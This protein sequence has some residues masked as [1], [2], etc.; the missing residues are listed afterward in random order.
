M[1][2]NPQVDIDTPSAPRKRVWFHAPQQSRLR[3]ALFQIH[4]WVGLIESL[5]VIVIGLSGSALVFRQELEQKIEP[6][7]HFVQPAS[8]SASWNAVVATICAGN[9]GFRVEALVYPRQADQSAYVILEPAREKVGRQQTRTYYFNPY[10][11]QVLGEENSLEGPLGWITNLHYYLFA[12]TS[13]LVVN[14][15]M[16]SGLFVLCLT[17]IVLWWPGIRRWTNALTIRLNSSWRRLNW[18]LHTVVGLWCSVVLAVIAFTGM[19]FAFPVPIGTVTVLATGGN[20]KQ[21]AALLAPPRLSKTNNARALSLDEV[22]QVVKSSFPADTSAAFLMFS[23]GPDGIYTAVGYRRDAAPYAQGITLSIDPH[24]GEILKRVG[25]TQYPLG[26][27]ITQYFYTLHFGSFGGNGA[28]GILVKILWVI[29]G[30]VAAALGVTGVLMYWN[31]YLS[32]KW[33]Q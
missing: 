31:R 22:L 16:A 14:G 17:G 23:D 5:Y 1:N 19:Y 9:P 11:G 3:R 12:G 28:L 2:M 4:L 13:G 6:H 27:R 15:V 25:T 20:P 24:S 32:K 10:S 26:M 18:D 8:Q 33:A 21:T 30:V 7:L 29:L